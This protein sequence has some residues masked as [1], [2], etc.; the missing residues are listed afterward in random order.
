MKSPDQMTLVGLVLAYVKYTALARLVK[1]RKKS[2][3]EELIGRLEEKTPTLIA[4]WRLRKCWRSAYSG[5]TFVNRPAH[6]AL[7]IR[8]DT[9]PLKDAE[10]P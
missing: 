8:R 2:L 3:T 10:K 1:A 6:W 7:D 4:G 9:K 5:T